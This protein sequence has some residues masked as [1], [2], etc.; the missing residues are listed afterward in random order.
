MK[1]IYFA[2]KYVLIPKNWLPGAKTYNCKVERLRN[3]YG[4]VERFD[5]EI[6]LY[7]DKYNVK[8]NFVLQINAVFIGYPTI[9]QAEV[10]I[11]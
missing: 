4:V 1:L 9:R 7:G 2:K 10:T 5:A 8:F 6:I 11:K 3:K